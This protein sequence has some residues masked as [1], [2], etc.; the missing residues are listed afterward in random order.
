MWAVLIRS[1]ARNVMR[2]NIPLLVLFTDFFHIN[3][4]KNLNADYTI[5]KLIHVL[6]NTRK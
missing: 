3:L 1:I 6:D 2:T 5:I 4:R